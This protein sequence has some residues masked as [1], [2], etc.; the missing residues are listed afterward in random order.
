MKKSLVV[1]FGIV[2]TA[3]SVLLFWAT[4]QHVQLP[5]WASPI[6]I[7]TTP[8][9]NLSNDYHDFLVRYAAKPAKSDSIAVVDIDEASLAEYGQWPWP[10][11][12]LA[13]LT[14]ELF[15]LG[16]EVI[17]FD[18]LFAEPDRTSPVHVVE[19]LNRQYET[20]ASIEH[21]PENF[22]N[23]DVL[24]AKELA[25]GK[26]VL[27]CYLSES[28]EGSV[29]KQRDVMLPKAPPYLSQG[30]GPFEWSH[31]AEPARTAIYP[32]PELFASATGIGSIKAQPDLDNILRRN[33]LVWQNT[34]GQLI[35]SLGLEAV[36]LF[37]GAEQ[38]IVHFDATGFINVRIA[39]DVI[40]TDR[41]GQILINYRTVD[42]AGHSFPHLSVRDLLIG[43]VAQEQV[44]G[45]ILFVGTSAAAM[46]DIKAIPLTPDF[47]GVET[48]A[49]IVDNVLAGDVIQEPA[50]MFGCEIMLI[51]L[52]GLFLTFLIH[53]GRPWLSGL[54]TVLV[55]ATA[56][57]TSM[58]LFESKYL[59]FNPAVLCVAVLAIYT[60]LTTIRY[61]QEEADRRRLRNLFGPMVSAKVLRFMEE[62][63]ERVKLEGQ[64]VDVTV[65]FSDIAGFTTMSEKLPA[66]EV[67][68]LLDRYLGCMNE[69]I[70][71]HDGFVDKFLG[72]SVMAVWGAPYPMVQ[73]A[74]HA[75]LAAIDQRD[76]M[77]SLRPTLKEE[78][79]HEIRIRMGLNSGLVKAG[80]MGC[81]DRMQ[82]T[83][84][85]D[86]VNQAARFEPLNKIYGTDIMI[87]ASTYE[88][89]KDS[90][91][92][93]MLDRLV[94]KGKSEPVVV[95]ELLGRKGSL[96]D[97]EQ[98]FVECY[99]RG[100]QDHWR[101]AWE[102]AL[103][104]LDQAAAIRSGDPSVLLLT[105][106]IR[107][108]RESP[109]P[110]DWQGAHILQ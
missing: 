110:V 96:S 21:L 72:D 74:S 35:P 66:E 62:H 94:V 108:F 33:S 59:L 34:S 98:R 70:Q 48:H 36:R 85:A 49:T 4:F 56:M 12:V 7:V 106:R 104:A 87:G 83:V 60:V 38:G 99:E 89:A 54:I 23:F 1:V 45:K 91:E 17:L 107:M 22:S 63:P 65:F 32:L 41:F 101:Q 103:E 14:R 55:V 30:S 73:H 68:K 9:R 50:W 46:K 93:R 15:S 37:R 95:Y 75:C 29:A 86:A 102:E 10:R 6:G 92:A 43:K 44:Q 19:Q 79:G 40:P 90:V 28:T 53:K 20:H 3:V 109:P 64:D 82:Y 77:E 16:A 58:Y 47:S 2:L 39:R 100:L 52:V 51:G 26:S 80:N 57:I 69:I 81:E 71:E 76:A 27:G 8:L 97:Q 11:Y 42:E 61:W 25:K 78:F 67:R 84:I 31:F 105:K 13:N 24:F 18:I 5:R 88:L